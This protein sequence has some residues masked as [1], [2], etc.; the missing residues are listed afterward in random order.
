GRGLADLLAF[1]VLWTR[2]LAGF[3]PLETAP[4]IAASHRV[5]RGKATAIADEAA[6]GDELAVFVDRRHPVARGQCGELFLPGGEKRIGADHKPTCPQWDKLR[7]HSIEVAFGAGV[8]D[9]EL[10]PEAVSRRQCILG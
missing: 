6:G 4:S 7:E 2:H 10:K 5:S 8:E 1:G 9:I 3:F